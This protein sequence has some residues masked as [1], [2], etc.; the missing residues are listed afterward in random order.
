MK[1]WTPVRRR[2]I[3]LGYGLLCHLS[4]LVAVTLMAVGLYTGM[5]SGQGQLSGWIAW[6]GN[7]ALLA[8]FP[9]LHSW[10]LTAAGR[11]FLAKLA[12]RVW[13]K[14]LVPTAYATIA[15][16]QLILVFVFWS[17]SDLVWSS[18]GGSS[19]WVP[20]VA[21]L[22]AWLF[23]GKALFDAGLGLQ[24]GAIGWTAMWRGEQPR[25]PSMPERG[26]FRRCRQPIYLGFALT[27]WTGPVWTP[28]HLFLALLWTGY[29]IVGPKHKE[30][31]FR[32]LHGEDFAR[33]QSRVP[34]FIPRLFS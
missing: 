18:P 6:L 28:D 31:R 17:P 13:G 3:A 23:L 4:F 11:N 20:A 10:L 30:Q 21:F 12:P 9:L 32:Q 22:L 26:L 16:W 15:S 27:L 7:L 29:C 33:Y 8:Q 14:A 5:Q 1:A 34:Y 2:G 24:T 19:G 25:Y